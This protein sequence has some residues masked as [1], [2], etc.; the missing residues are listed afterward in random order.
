[1]GE[2]GRQGKLP[3]GYLVLRPETNHFY[4]RFLDIQGKRKERRLY[5]ANR[6]EAIKMAGRLAVEELARRQGLIREKN[7]GKRTLGEAAAAFFEYAELH[8]TTKTI[9]LVAH[10]IQRKILPFFGAETPIELITVA[11]IQRFKKHLI[12]SKQKPQTVNRTLTTIS[13][14][15]KQALE[16]GW[17]ETMPYIKRLPVDEEEHGYVLN[18]AEIT[19]LVESARAISPTA[20]RYLALGLYCGLRHG[21]AVGLEWK[22]IE[23]WPDPS[24]AVRGLIH[25]SRQKHRKSKM[26][27]PLT[28]QARAILD[29]TPEGEREGYILIWGGKPVQ[30]LRKTWRSILCGAGLDDLVKPDGRRLGYHDL[31]HTFTSR[32][33]AALGYDARFFSGHSSADGFRRYL[34]GSPERVF[35]NARSPFEQEFEK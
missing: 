20:L 35:R 28:T 5:A 21:E 6:A 23:F 9:E 15:F 19:A 10:H 11:E 25:L 16:T 27:R 13:G 32:W 29:E 33:F 24:G 31:R 34:H 7:I 2:R 3:L 14:V 22:N 1:M 18:D 17:I 26:P 4:W 8:C 12:E 30:Q